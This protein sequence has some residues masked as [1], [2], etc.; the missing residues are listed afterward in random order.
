MFGYVRI[1]EP[2]LKVKEMD[3]YR[4]TYCGLCLS[5]GR[6]FG[7]GSR[8]Y[9]NYDMTFLALC[10]LAL[11]GQTPTFI[12]KRCI[13]H[14]TR[15]K[16]MMADH[17]CLQYAAGAGMQLVRMKAEDDLNDEKGWKAFKAR[18]VKRHVKNKCR[19][20]EKMYPGLTALLQERMETFK[21]AEEAKEPS[22]DIPAEAFGHVL[23]DLFAYGT[24]GDDSVLLS[25][26]GFH[27]GKWIYILDAVDDFEEDIKE[28]R[29]NPLHLLYKTNTLEEYQIHELELALSGEAAAVERAV[30]LFPKEAS[31][32]AAILKNILFLGMPQQFRSITEKM[33]KKDERS[34]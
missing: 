34:I 20:A 26:I 33:R 7:Q 25:N 31:D 1:F 28:K 5:S 10:R 15:K 21:K 23:A 14:P 6:H 8:L 19:K 29:F 11:S 2:E 18:I 30:D 3:L 22:A 13:A 16:Q 12:Q 17:E 27:L 32:I 9:L 24:S 4:A